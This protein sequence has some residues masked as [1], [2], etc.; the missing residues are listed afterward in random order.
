MELATFLEALGWLMLSFVKFVIMPSTGIAAG[1]DP[2]RTFAYSSGGAVAGL[3]LMQPVI[4]MFFDWRSRVRQR[5]GKRAFT[6]GRRRIVRVK[7]RFGIVGIAALGG[8]VGVP[9]GALLAFKYFGHRSSTLP[10][11][12]VGY[13]AWSALLTT[14]SA[15]ALI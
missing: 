10:A 2:W 15:L 9:V 4:R 1:L 13:I 8:V 11:M 6:A 12:I 3:L 14:L 7:Q 5:K